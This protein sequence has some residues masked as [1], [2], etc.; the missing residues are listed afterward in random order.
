MLLVVENSISEILRDM[1]PEFQDLLR[2][3]I[4]ASKQNL[5]NKVVIE[6]LKVL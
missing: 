4:F 3:L 5:K 2:T 1:V 6:P